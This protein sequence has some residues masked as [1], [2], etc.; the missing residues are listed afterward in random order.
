[1]AVDTPAALVARAPGGTLIEL[2]LDGEAQP[3]LP[4]VTAIAGVTSADAQANVLRAFSAEGGQVIPALIA[5]AEGAA[6]K[7]T[8]IH[9]ASPNLETLF[10]SLTGR[11]LD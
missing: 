3:L 2:T 10:I 1:L 11:K 4:L 7:V 6:R 5:V 9:L 8:N